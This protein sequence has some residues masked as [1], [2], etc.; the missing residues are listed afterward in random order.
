MANAGDK[1]GNGSGL[2]EAEE[3]KMK[4]GRF[5]I[6]LKDRLSRHCDGPTERE[7]QFKR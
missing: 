3:V 5:K 7:G 6:C 4:R 2:E 1:V